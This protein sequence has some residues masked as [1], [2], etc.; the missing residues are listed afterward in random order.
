VAH[1]GRIR[2]QEERFGDQRAESRHSQAQNVAGIAGG[3]FYGGGGL[4]RHRASLTGSTGIRARRYATDFM[5]PRVMT[6]DTKHHN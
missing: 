6:K 1:N 2:Q 5:T 3:T 4:V